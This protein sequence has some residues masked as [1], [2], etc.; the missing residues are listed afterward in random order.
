MGLK[1]PCVQVAGAVSESLDNAARRC[2]SHIGCNYQSTSLI[3]PGAKGSLPHVGTSRV[4]AIAS[5][6]EYVGLPIRVGRNEVA[7]L[8]SFAGVEPA[9]NSE[10]DVEK[11]RSHQPQSMPNTGEGL[12]RV[13]QQVAAA[14]LFLKTRTRGKGQA[15]GV[16]R[17]GK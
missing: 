6:N 15:R 16:T 5:A 4:T 2:F 1:W 8:T 12:V 14:M 3:S 7:R 10:V 17:K 9:T 11:M 13:L